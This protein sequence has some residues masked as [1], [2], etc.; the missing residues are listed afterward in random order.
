MIFLGKYYVPHSKSL[1]LILISINLISC[2]STRVLNKYCYV[3]SAQKIADKSIKPSNG[4]VNG[5]IA[6][7]TT[8][9]V[10]GGTIGATAAM[11]LTMGTFGIFLPI[12]PVLVISGGVIGGLVGSVVGGTT[13]Y[14]Y[15]YFHAGTGT[16]N[17]TIYCNKN[18]EL[19]YV[20]ESTTIHNKTGSNINQIESNTNNINIYSVVQISDKIFNNNESVILKLDKDKL[21]IDKK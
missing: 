13:G 3:H 6:G 21:F 8:G 12:I 14:S 4:T 7:G 9:I 1:S 16:Y 15:D 11:T 10:I 18:T 17:Y 2:S 19:V 5:F 20:K